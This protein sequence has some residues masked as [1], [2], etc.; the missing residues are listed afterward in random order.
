M[1][2]F[3]DAVRTG[4]T[5]VLNL[6]VLMTALPAFAV[7]VTASTPA[8]SAKQQ[9]VQPRLPAK[10]PA[11]A[12]VQLHTFTELDGQ[13]FGA[14]A[15]SIV[16]LDAAG[17]QI[18]TFPTGIA[19]ASISPHGTSALVVGDLVSR[20]VQ[21]MDIKTGVLRPVLN[22]REVRDSQPAAAPGGYLLQEGAFSSVASDGKNLFVAVGSGFSSAIFKIDP[23]TRQIVARSWASAADPQA[24]VYKNGALFVLVGNG[25]QVRRFNDVLQRNLENI[26]LH[27]PGARG[28]GIRAGEIVRLHQGRVISAQVPAVE[29]TVDK[30]NTNVDRIQFVPIKVRLPVIKLNVPKRYAV[31]ITGD[32]AENFWGECFWNDTVWMY[33]TLLANGYAPENIFVLY[34]DGGDYNSANPAYRHP[35][36]VTD[37]AA[38]IPN[39][40]L[41]LDGLKNG[42]P[43]HGIPQMDGN[44]TLF[45]WTFDHG[46]K[47]GAQSTLCLRDGQMGANAF[48][49]KLNAIQYA[50]RAVFMQQCYSGGFIDLLKNPKTFISTAA[51][52][53]QVA[54]PSDNEN[55]MY[56][57]KPFSH[58]EYNY[59]VIGALNR[60]TPTNAPVNA[61]ANSDTSI[62]MLEMHMWEAGHKSTSETPQANDMG[63]IGNLF[64]LKKN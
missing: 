8:A 46:G 34:G 18:R 37:F 20:N 64:R 59:W 30:I 42:D 33:K 6:M 29:L 14:G 2:K 44:D 43:A 21:T 12:A 5:A 7:P 38:T 32:R 17:K 58:G 57:N 47:S 54:Y 63:G 1:K 51:R 15:Q 10:Q 27:T 24:M 39:V 35:T 56:G 45:V 62:S 23:A 55:E 36:R 26:D 49:A 41:V 25:S 52:A 61:D 9:V 53:D 31:L 13:M 60:L 50:Q 22:L 11:Q 40:N 3:S 48:A 19:S 28:I 4:F 16:S